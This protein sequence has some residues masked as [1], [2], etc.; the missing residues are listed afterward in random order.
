MLLT[1]E[2]VT[3]AGC[4]GPGAKLAVQNQSKF[5]AA[6]TAVCPIVMFARSSRAAVRGVAPLV[7]LSEASRKNICMSVPIKSFAPASSR[8]D[9]KRKG[10]IRSS[11]SRSAPVAALRRRDAERR[12]VLP[13]L[14]RPV[15]EHDGQGRTE[16]R[17]RGHRRE[18]PLNKFT[19]LS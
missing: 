14:A 6:R 15:C 8:Y 16:R 2:H 3:C 19:M 17:A 13:D 10:S 4:R 7:T 12:L 5:I 11:L 1:C 18:R 9:T